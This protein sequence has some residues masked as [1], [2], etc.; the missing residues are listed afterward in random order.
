MVRSESESITV[1][2]NL[3]IFQNIRYPMH[4][5]FCLILLFDLRYG[6]HVGHSIV[7]GSGNS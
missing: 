1:K 4:G 6:Y 2:I 5:N 7:L 3:H